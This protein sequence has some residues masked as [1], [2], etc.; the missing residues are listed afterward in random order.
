MSLNVSPADLMDTAELVSANREYHTFVGM[1]KGTPLTVASHGIGG[2][3]ASCCFEE[4][5]QA[6]M[7]GDVYFRA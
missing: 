6:G 1:W 5:I 3:G 7:H 2:A 4:L